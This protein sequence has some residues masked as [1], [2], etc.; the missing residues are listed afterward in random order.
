M[1]KWA[2]N[3]PSITPGLDVEQVAS[4]KRMLTNYRENLRLIEERMSEYVEFNQIPLQDV[5]NKDL[6]EA[7]IAELEQKLG[8]K[9]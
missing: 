3:I 4:W 1:P 8:I 2:T 9:A 7:K 6:T 5:K